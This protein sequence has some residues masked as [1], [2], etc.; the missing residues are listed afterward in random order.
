MTTETVMEIRH[1]DLFKYLRNAK[2]PVR[3]S[4]VAI[5]VLER[6]T[7]ERLGC[8]ADD[9]D[10]SDK[11][12]EELRQKVNIFLLHLVERWKKAKR[13]INRFKTDN[14]KWLQNVFFCQGQSMYIFE[15]LTLLK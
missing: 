5:V 15:K 2:I 8:T 7:K 9:E 11:F 3:K 14:T 13:Q 1:I 10:I 12:K 4:T 6:F